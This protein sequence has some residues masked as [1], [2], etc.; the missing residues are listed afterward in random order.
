M[1][2]VFLSCLTVMFL[3]DVHVL[4]EG[5]NDDDVYPLTN[6]QLYGNRLILCFCQRLMI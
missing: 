1:E 6:L 4:S 3:G 2:M 5:F